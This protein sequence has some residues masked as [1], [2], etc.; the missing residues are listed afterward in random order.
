MGFEGR[1]VVNPW[2]DNRNGR[3]YLAAEETLDELV[4]ALHTQARRT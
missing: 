1:E 2:G 3:W 4:A